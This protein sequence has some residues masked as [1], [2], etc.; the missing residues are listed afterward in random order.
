MEAMEAK[1]KNIVT[2]VDFLGQIDVDDLQMGLVAYLSDD[3]LDCGLDMEFFSSAIGIDTAEHVLQQRNDGL[4]FLTTL[5]DVANRNPV[6]PAVCNAHAAAIA[7]L[8]GRRLHQPN[9]TS[10][11]RVPNVCDS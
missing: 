6:L 8:V 9:T 5:L 4:V 11:P 3:A 1:Q 2:D 10:A 7:V